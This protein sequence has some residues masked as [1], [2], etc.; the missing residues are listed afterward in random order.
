[1]QHVRE[2]AR[3]HIVDL[4]TLGANPWFRDDWE[5]RV[6]DRDG[7]PAKLAEL[8]L[9]KMARFGGSAA[10]RQLIKHAYG[11][12]GQK[13]VGIGYHSVVLRDG[14]NVQKIHYRHDGDIPAQQQ[15]ASRLNRAHRRVM[16][17]F[18]DLAVPQAFFVGSSPLHLDQPYVV[19]RQAYVENGKPS[20][21]RRPSKAAFEFLG[22]ASRM[23]EETGLMPDIV[24]LGNLLDTPRGPKLV[25][26]IPLDSQS[27]ADGPA[28]SHALAILEDHGIMARGAA[29]S[30]R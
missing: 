20:N 12:A 28:I 25:D 1:M 2:V 15:E 30:Y 23:F 17:E 14:N 7:G 5:Q 24:G 21:M 29:Q 27:P 6:R 8:G 26:T 10:C 3:S 9:L 13:V 11:R 18:E 19:A 4:A 22:R 16:V